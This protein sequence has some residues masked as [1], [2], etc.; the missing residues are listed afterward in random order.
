MELIFADFFTAT[1][2]E[3]GFPLHYNLTLPRRK[4]NFGCTQRRGAAE[5]RAAAKKNSVPGIKG[6]VGIRIFLIFNIK[7]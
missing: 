4:G 1:P 6:R 7:F 5:L 2:D 3:S